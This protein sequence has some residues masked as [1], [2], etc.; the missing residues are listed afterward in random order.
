MKAPVLALHF[1]TVLSPQF[2]TQ[3]LAPSKQMPVGAEPTVNVLVV[4]AELAPHLSRAI[5]NGVLVVLVATAVSPEPSPTKA[6]AV[7]VPAVTFP[8]VK[9]PLPSRFTIV[10]G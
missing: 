7:T 9:F 8:V 10:P 5:C 4:F 3:M 2:A 6:V 1:V